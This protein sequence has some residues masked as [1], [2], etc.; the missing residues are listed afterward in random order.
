[1]YDRT[2]G[3]AVFRKYVSIN[4]A[5]WHTFKHAAMQIWRFFGNTLFAPMFHYLFPSVAFFTTV[6]SFPMV[7]AFLQWLK[8]SYPEVRDLLNEAI[9]V[10]DPGTPALCLLQ[11]MKFLFEFIIPAVCEQ[12]S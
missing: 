1:M 8:L 9:R 3:G 5:Y 11:D 4:M 6:S 12:Q 7:Q 10:Q 2:D